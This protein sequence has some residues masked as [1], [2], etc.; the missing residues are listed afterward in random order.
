[1]EIDVVSV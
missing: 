1:E